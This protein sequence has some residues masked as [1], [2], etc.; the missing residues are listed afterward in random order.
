MSAV[1]IFGR[2]VLFS[3]ISN[4]AGDNIIMHAQNLA[5]KDGTPVDIAGQLEAFGQEYRSNWPWSSIGNTCKTQ[6]WKLH[7]S[8]TPVEITA[9]FACIYPILKRFQVPF[10]IAQD[11]MICA[12]LNEGS[13]GATQIG[14]CITIYADEIEDV[15]GLAQALIQASMPFNGPEIVSDIYLGGQVFARYGA[16]SPVIQRDALGQ[17]HAYIY[18]PDGTMQPDSY[19]DPADYLALGGLPFKGPDYALTVPALFPREHVL[20][21]RYL[22]IDVLDQRP[23]GATF[24]AI[25]IQGDAQNIAPKLIKQ[26]RFHT[27]SD[28]YGRDIRDRFRH[29]Q[30]MHAIADATGVVPACTACFEDKG[31]AYLVFD[32]VYGEPLENAIA[33]MR[34]NR[35]WDILDT[36]EQDN[37]LA[38]MEHAAACVESLHGVGIVHRDISASNLH[39]TTDGHV[40]LIDLELAMLAGSGEQP[41][42]K[43]TPGFMAP[44][45]EQGAAPAFAQDVHALGAAI[46]FAMTGLDPRRFR[47][48]H[49]ESHAGLCGLFAGLPEE[50]YT[51][52]LACFGPPDQRPS[53]LELKKQ[54]Q[55]A[56]AHVMKNP[57]SV[58]CA[59]RDSLREQARQALQ[60][61]LNG[62]HS[63]CARR[64]QDGL[65][66]SAPISRQNNRMSSQM[67]PMELRRSLNRGVAGVGYLL[68]II[69]QNPQDLLTDELKKSASYAALWL[70]QHENTPDLALPGLHFGEAG[71][72]LALHHLNRAGLVKDAGNFTPIAT[73]WPDI[74]HGLAGQGLFAL[75]L[76]QNDIACACALNLMDTQNQDGSWTMPDGVPGMSGE[77]L[78]GFAHGTAGIAYFLAEYG[79]RCTDATA[80]G[81]AVK[82]TEWM[83]SQAQRVNDRLSWQY[84]D[85]NPAVWNWWC[86]GAMGIATLFRSLW[87]YTG[88]KHYSTLLEQSLY[89][90]AQGF[91]AANLSLCHGM[92]GLGIMQL[93]AFAAT[94]DERYLSE[95]ESIIG[96]I[97]HRG[98]RTG[99]AL[100]WIVEDP[101]YFTGDLMVGMGGVLLL[102]YYYAHA[103]DKVL[104]PGNLEP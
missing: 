5:L 62:L 78:S 64:N 63:I 94:G 32:Y 18:L 27:L 69:G 37:I 87:R 60:A 103:Q 21:G 51:C 33:A 102:L 23:R 28:F 72:A 55:A 11:V 80:F 8:S 59:Q 40:I 89:A 36:K 81:A 73:T 48:Q 68:G 6:G 43:G 52:L 1:V 15:N 30:A 20:E 95:A 86:H 4:C 56:R 88:D 71:V 82:A 46:V 47:L 29:Q 66:L 74:T 9:L 84:S 2:N 65:W 99:D 34:A 3:S 22:I 50:F 17:I 104:F 67:Q 12:L 96:H 45:Q 44:E 58:V 54:L 76:A 35:R 19:G 39:V 90:P 14:K 41:F 49:L 16:F 85:R 97:L 101:H 25:D 92:S 7:I 24:Q 83:K 79:A 53:V 100:G 98:I 10:K 42:G 31:S 93:E 75:T 61:G 70:Q 38:L 26:G 57:V 13:F 91:S 77:T